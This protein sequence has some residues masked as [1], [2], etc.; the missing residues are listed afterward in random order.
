MKQDNS[1]QI[2]ALLLLFIFDKMDIPI[3]EATVSEMCLRN[4]WV[5]YMDYS[6][7]FA[8]IL[9]QKW[10]CPVEGSG[11]ATAG[12][13]HYTMSADGRMCLALLY[14]EIPT[15]LRASVVEY[16]N[17]NRMYFRRRQEY[18][19]DYYPNP[20]GTF[21]VLL[22][23][24]DPARPVLEVVLTVDTRALAKSIHDKWQ[25][26]APQVYGALHDILIE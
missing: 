14:A 21:S 26:K 25:Q 19:S 16:V 8:Q 10:I 4:S 6:Q 5:G 3:T 11:S 13:V 22:R 17:A 2:N 15:S 9:E 23:I 24:T 7:A 18:F 1:N 12:E 20:D